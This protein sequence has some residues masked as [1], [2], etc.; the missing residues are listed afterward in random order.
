MKHLVENGK[1][2]RTIYTYGKDSEQILAFFGTDKKLKNIL[3]V[4]VADFYKSDALLKTSKNDKPRQPE[5][6]RKT[7]LVLKRC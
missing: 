2:P 6:V 1:K 4:H 3:P 7:K 5:T